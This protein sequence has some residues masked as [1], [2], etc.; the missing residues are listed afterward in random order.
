VSNLGLG[1]VF[2]ANM[3]VNVVLLGFGVAGTGGLPVVSPL[4]AGIAFLAGAGAGGRLASRV[5]RP[6]RVALAIEIALIALACALAAAIDVQ[7]DRASGDTIVGLLAV[8]MGVR[9]ATVRKL[10]VPDLTTT[11]LTMTLTGLAADSPAAGGTGTG[12][13]RRAVAVSAMFAG[14]VAGALLV[15]SSLVLPL[16]AAA[17]LGL[18]AMFVADG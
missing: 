4:L 11:V 7:P 6:L 3:T 15:R 17:A 16:L 8:A 1:H 10:G 13:V 12:S 14:A 5:A 9:N 2:S 18:V